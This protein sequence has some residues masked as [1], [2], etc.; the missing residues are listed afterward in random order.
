M[1]AVIAVVGGR[2]I[3]RTRLDARVA[4]LRR[5]PL[6]RRFALA[7]RDEPDLVGRLAA[8]QLVTEEILIIE[9]EAADVVASSVGEGVGPDGP[10][11]G[12][13]ASLAQRVT[14]NVVIPEASVRAF[15]ERNRDRFEN[16]ETRGVRHILV[17]REVMAR[18]LVERI[19]AGDRFDTL[20]RTHSIDPGSRDS[21]GDLGDI[22]R[23]VLPRVLENAIFDA[24]V[25]AVVGPIET[26]HGWHLARVE[27][28]NESRHARYED[29]RA[30]IQ[31]ELL[32]SERER[33]FDEWLE[34][35]RAELAVV[36]SEYAYWAYP[37][38]G[39]PSHRH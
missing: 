37:V 26:E 30:S 36:A 22:G 24:P 3:T 31:A 13:I 16:L 25:G 38:K 17:A 5:G 32:V 27:R 9:A 34:R 12:V 14:A 2:P 21:A 15:Y 29:V 35:R 6:A 33:V 8:R 23:G 4:A 7:A 19:Q 10:F 1:S 18:W 28:R 11:A 20:A 39:I